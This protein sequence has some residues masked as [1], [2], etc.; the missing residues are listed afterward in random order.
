MQPNP[1]DFARLQQ[2]QH[3]YQQN[4]YAMPAIASAMQSAMQPGMQQ[5]R[6]KNKQSAPSRMHPPPQQQYPYIPMIGN[7]P[8]PMIQPQPSAGTLSPEAK[9][10][11]QLFG[12]LNNPRYSQSFFAQLSNEN[13]VNFFLHPPIPFIYTPF[14]GI[15]HKLFHPP[16]PPNG[17]EIM[18]DPNLKDFD[19]LYLVCYFAKSNP[20]TIQQPNYKLSV[21][22]SII[23]SHFLGEN[24]R[25]FCWKANRFPLNYLIKPTLNDCIFV[26]NFCRRKTNQELLKDFGIK[27]NSPDECGKYT[28]RC[29]TCSEDYEFEIF[30]SGAFLEK[31]P[32]MLCEKCKT[33]LKISELQ[34]SPFDR[35]RR[36]FLNI[37]LFQALIKR[38]T[39][40]N[41]YE[42]DI[43][44][45]L[46]NN[47]FPKREIMPNLHIG[48]T[49]QEYLDKSKSMFEF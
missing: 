15:T 41:N 13:F 32:D 47:E 21:D 26:V 34:I 8:A 7:P 23:E 20:P 48:E 10:V 18:L 35:D 17:Y 11:A 28:I 43:N 22:K 14:P 44:L 5:F 16:N 24:N 1:N 29:P 25:F 40:A 12:S 46:D 4:P 39:N 31:N 30:F 42:D 36:A 33:R 2:Q 6:R 19:K 37:Q 9:Q 45:I 38:N 3:M 27:I 49:T